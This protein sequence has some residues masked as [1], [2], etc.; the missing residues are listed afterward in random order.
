MIAGVG[1]DLVEVARMEKILQRWQDRF[2]HRVFSGEEIS[3]CRRKAVPAL[4]FAA[5]FAAKEA[6]LKALGIGLGMGLAL[7]D[8]ATVRDAAGTPSLSFAA[9]GRRMLAQAGISRTH[10]SLTHTK[11]Y[12][13][14][15]VIMER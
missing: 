9:P 8:I 12:A 13:V 14:A 7:Q 4:H 15:L 3:Y 2:L 11:D 5:R 1:V 10:L 6:A